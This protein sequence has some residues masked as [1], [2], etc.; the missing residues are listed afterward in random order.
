MNNTQEELKTKIIQSS[1]FDNVGKETML[2]VLEDLTEEEQH[3]LLQMITEFDAGSD[4]RLNEFASKIQAAHKKYRDTIENASK[5]QPDRK[6]Q[7][8]AESKAKEKVYVNLINNKMT[9][10]TLQPN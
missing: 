2:N 10:T 9:K 7:L 3:E 8:I 5:I 1:L 6:K 4:R